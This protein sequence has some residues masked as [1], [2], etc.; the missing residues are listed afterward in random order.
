MGNQ[1]AESAL[2]TTPKVVVVM[3]AYNAAK[4][5][6]AT[7]AR[8][9]EGIASNIILVD[10]SS[11]DDTI[12]IAKRLASEIALTP[13]RHPHNVGYGGNQKTCYMEA[14]RQ[15]ADIV[16]MI[17]PDGQY[18]PEFL[19][20]IVRPIAEG[21]VDVVLGSRMLRARGAR[22]GGMPWWK[23]ISNHFLTACENAAFGRHL[24]EYHT[25]YRAFSRRFLETVP[26]LRNS[27][28]FVFDTEILAQAVAFGF[29]IK[30]VP[31]TTKYFPEASSI[32]FRVS[33]IYGTKTLW[34]VGRFLL[35]RLGFVSPLFRK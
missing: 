19:P 31:V 29:D 13:I 32:N 35:H 8:L 28:D 17:H 3:P 16:V 26:F 7:V 24:S 9:P 14:L 23:R 22:E 21:E 6:E 18:D 33:L 34:T 10:D 30:E 11:G 1:V 2:A 27:P 15:G 20:A 5:L 25:G 12:E 4:T